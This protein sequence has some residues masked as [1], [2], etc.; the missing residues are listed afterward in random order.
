MD[1]SEKVPGTV[2]YSTV[3]VPGTPGT[4]QHGTIC[5]DVGVG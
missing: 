2:V 4:V 5:H 1:Y 3:P